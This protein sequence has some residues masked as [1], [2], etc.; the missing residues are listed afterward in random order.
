MSAPSGECPGVNP[1]NRV[2]TGPHSG[3]LLAVRLGRGP[4]ALPHSIR[5]AYEISRAIRAFHRQGQTHGSLTLRS[6]ELG[7]G[8]AKVIPPVAGPLPAEAWLDDVRG[9]GEILQALFPYQAPAAAGFAATGVWSAARRIAARCLA[10]P[11][12]PDWNMQ[13]IVSELR[14]LH[15]VVRQWES[16][17][18]SLATPHRQ[19]TRI[20]RARKT[21][22]A[23]HPPLLAPPANALPVPAVPVS[24]AAAERSQPQLQM[25]ETRIEP[26]VSTI[27]CPRCAMASVFP[28]TPRTDFEETLERFRMPVMRCHRCSYRYFK[29]FVLTIPKGAQN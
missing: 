19:S 22:A 23:G 8:E 12:I 3:E 20:W 16:T 10:D 27:R 18:R 4:L 2:E 6:I 15:V 25:Q 9:F 24:Q 5:C 7:S 17:A 21:H 28:S 13:R 11:P 26:K 1:Q 29:V 14:L